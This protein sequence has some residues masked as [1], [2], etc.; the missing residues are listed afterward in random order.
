[1]THLPGVP[2]MDQDV[3]LVTYEDGLLNILRELRKQWQEEDIVIKPLGPNLVNLALLCSCKNDEEDAVV[4]RVNG[5]VI[6]LL[7]CHFDRDYEFTVIR[8]LQQ[9]SLGASVVMTFRNGFCMEYIQ[10]Q[11]YDWTDCF[12]KDGPEQDEFMRIVAREIACYHCLTTANAAKQM[13]FETQPY[14]KKHCQTILDV[15]PHAVTNASHGAQRIREV[16][17]HD[18]FATLERELHHTYD[19]LDDLDLPVTFCHCDANPTNFIYRAEDK[20]AILVD[21]EGCCFSYPAYDLATHFF[22]SFVGSRPDIDKRLPS[23]EFIDK[24]LKIYFEERRK[25]GDDITDIEAEV[26]KW[27]IHIS[28]MML[29][30]Y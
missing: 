18:P 16:F 27:M 15:I 8:L 2:H 29:V 1:M 25:L 24:W 17:G 28:R 3:S 13:G 26:K 10:G 19:I 20:R 6:K 5:K 7:P 14:F 22:L 9:R 11:H 12:Y 23:D 4:A 21:C 30:I